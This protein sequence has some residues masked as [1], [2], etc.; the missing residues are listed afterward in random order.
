MRQAGYARERM[1]TSICVVDPAE[2]DL[3]QP[4]A[5]GVVLTLLA[6]TQMMGMDDDKVEGRSFNNTVRIA[7][8]TPY[9]RKI[10]C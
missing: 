7:C 3:L 5:S 10:S 6:S 9:G 4:G 1:V 8:F 2:W